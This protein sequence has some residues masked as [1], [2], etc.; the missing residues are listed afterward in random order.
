MDDDFAVDL[1]ALCLTAVTVYYAA[2]ALLSIAYVFA[3]VLWNIW[4]GI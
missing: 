4:S 1:L 3:S 2:M